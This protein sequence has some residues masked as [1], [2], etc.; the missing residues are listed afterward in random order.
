LKAIQRV[1]YKKLYCKFNIFLI[2][3]HYKPMLCNKKNLCWCGD[4]K[5]VNKS[6][7]AKWIL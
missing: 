2:F 7:K 4:I 1:V 5:L 6:K 3:V